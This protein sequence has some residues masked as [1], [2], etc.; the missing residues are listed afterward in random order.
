MEVK[1][2]QGRIE[3]EATDV[4]VLTHY[5]GETR[6]QPEAERVDKA[7]EGFLSATPSAQDG[8]HP[9]AQDDPSAT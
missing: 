3:K 4:L 8:S 2:K 6:L 5:E 1:V 9:P 7:A